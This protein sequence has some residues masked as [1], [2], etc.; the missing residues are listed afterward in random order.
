MFATQIPEV[1]PQWVT[2]ALKSAG[3][4]QRGNVTHVTTQSL[5]D[6]PF[7]APKLRRL[8]V[9]YSADAVCRLPD[10]LILKIAKREKEHFFYTQIAKQM[11]D[12]PIPECY[13]A[14][15]DADKSQATFLLEDLSA[16]HFQTEW[17]VPPTQ[18][19]CEAAIDGLANVHGFW[20]DDP[21]LE[22]YFRA[23]VTKGNCWVGRLNEAIQQLPA[24]LDFIGDRLSEGRKRIY[25]EVLASSNPFWQPDT[26]RKA[27]T[28]LHG[29]IHFW[30]VLFP[31][32]HEIHTIRIFDWNSWDIGKGT[33]DLVYMIGL[34]WYPSLRRRFERPLLERYHRKLLESDIGAYSWDDC[35]LD[36]RES[37]IM[38]LFIPVWQWQRR[39]IPA[40]VWWSHLERSFL[41]FDDLHCEELL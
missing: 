19:L 30:N 28:L 5:S 25:E 27:K 11:T 32:N 8:K 4:L 13:F 18:S 6:V 7:G 33:N 20:W 31:H 1:T 23:K 40:A 21:R 16:T 15:Q 35:W 22:T 10:H 38:N 29:D 36:Y 12:P 3:H 39:N 26:A 41:T 17:P 37:C 24:F 9:A 34:H 2:E 14:A